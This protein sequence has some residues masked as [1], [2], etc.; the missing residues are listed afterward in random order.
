MTNPLP[1]PGWYAD[2]SG[3]AG[4]RYFDGANWSAHRAPP[5][6]SIVIHN[7]V[8]TAAPVM[9]RSGPNHVL[10]LVLTLLT[11][12]LWLPVWLLVTIAS[13][14]P[15]ISVASLGQNRPGPRT[16]RIIAAAV[17]GLILVGLA[18][19][20]PISFLALG[21]LAAAGYLGYRAYERALERGAEATRIAARA[22]AQH[23]AILS[24]DDFGR[25]GQYPPNPL[26]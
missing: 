4:Q 1:P 15:A 13:I 22:D 5:P 18:M 2:P 20:H 17:G 21:L 16:V 8:G 26:R 9:V 12:G 25:Y 10:H 7:T 14:R 24:G 3:A 6:P 11:G 23:R 19:E